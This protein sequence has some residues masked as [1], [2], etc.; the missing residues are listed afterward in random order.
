MSV[1]SLV[2]N[3][4]SDI[5]NSY[6]LNREVLRKRA[7]DNVAQSVS[8]MRRLVR[9]EVRESTRSEARTY[10]SNPSTPAD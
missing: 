10:N 6:T 7:S 4:K 1:K 2:D 3:V 9:E 5:L 8:E